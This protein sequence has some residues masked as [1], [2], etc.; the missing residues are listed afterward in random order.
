MTYKEIQDA[1]LL[2]RFDETQRAAIKFAINSRYGRLWA[3]EPWSFK[4]ALVSFAVS[5]GDSEFTLTELGLQKVEAVFSDLPSD[6]T[7][8]YADRPEMALQWAET[9]SGTSAAYTL[10][11]D[12]LRLDRPPTSATDLLV[13]GQKKW[14]PLVNDSD[15]PLI[16]AEYHFALVV[17]AAADMLLRE[18]DPT[19][20]GE[21]KS[22]N[23]QVNEMRM[24]Y[25]SNMQ[26]QTAYPS[27]PY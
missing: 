25:M 4:R 26:T 5:A 16:P 11:G 2:D 14:A 8:M 20:Q 10:M 9:S 1:V 7:R 27:W 21:E 23:D 3:L 13:V 12:T 18:A 6:F 15:V 17:G 19:W 22:F 24:S